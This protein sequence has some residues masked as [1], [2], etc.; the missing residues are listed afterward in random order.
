MNSFKLKV[1]NFSNLPS[2]PF[3]TNKTVTARSY[4]LDNC[5][6]TIQHHFL[7][8]VPTGSLATCSTVPP[9]V[10][11]IISCTSLFEST[12][13]IILAFQLRCIHYFSSFSL[14]PHVGLSIYTHR[15]VHQTP[16]KCKKPVL[17]VHTFVQF[18][19][20]Y[21]HILVFL[22]FQFLVFWKISYSLSLSTHHHKSSWWDFCCPEKKKYKKKQ[23]LRRI[24]F[25]H[26]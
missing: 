25:L 9:H 1:R 2:C 4:P 14:S 16:F 18:C 12:K 19:Y 6:V 20:F 23:H 15:M 10:F 26:L 13:S 24:S 7:T 11:V 5:Q 21:I 3:L 8:H 17:F 22:S